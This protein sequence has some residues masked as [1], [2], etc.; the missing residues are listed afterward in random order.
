M[1]RRLLIG[2]AMAAVALAAVLVVVGRWEGRHHARQE[3][4]GMRKVL[5]AIGQLDNQTLSMYRVN[6]G[7]GFDCLLY[8][9][10]TNRFA[11]EVCFDKP[12]RVIETLDRRGSGDPKISSVREDPGSSK[13]HVDRALADRLLR[14]LGAPGY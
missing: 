7:F 10:G 9:R 11:L 4:R 5:A 2:V 3:M 1:T 6:V 8:K 14:R 12:G 13:L